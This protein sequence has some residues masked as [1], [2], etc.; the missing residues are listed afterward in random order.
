MSPEIVFMNK[1]LDLMDETTLKISAL[2]AENVELRDNFMNQEEDHEN[3]KVRYEYLESQYGETTSEV[4]NFEVVKDQGLEEITKL[5]KCLDE[6]LNK[7]VISKE[8][9]E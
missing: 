8:A 6:A 3:L 1:M 4:K 9:V 7:I 2:E 5:Q